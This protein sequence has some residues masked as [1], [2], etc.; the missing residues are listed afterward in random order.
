MFSV[1]VHG[2]REAAGESSEEPE[3]LLVELAPA[4]QLC[5]AGVSGN[6]ASHK[7]KGGG[8]L[9]TRHSHVQNGRPVLSRYRMKNGR[10]RC[11]QKFCLDQGALRP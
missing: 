11:S 4:G 3:A 6:G 5:R 2:L 10:I 1:R 9:S 8:L 7:L